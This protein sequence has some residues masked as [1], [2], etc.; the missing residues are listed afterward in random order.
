MDYPLRK[1]CV[2]L[3]VWKL[4]CS[5]LKSFFLSRISKA[6]FDFSKKHKEEKFRFWNKNHGLS[7]KKNVP[8][9]RVFKNLLFRSKIYSFLSRISKNNIFWLDFSKKPKKEKFRFLAKKNGISPY[10]NDHFFR[11][12]KTL[13]F[14][15]KMYSFL[16][17]IPR[18]DLYKHNYFKNTTK[19]IVWS[20]AKAMD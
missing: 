9:F 2:F 11:P 15:S 5:G 6:I 13:V 16:S 4:Y 3:H 12:F 17:R 19:E 1:M 7:P 10:K 8:F 18:N 20:L 14:W